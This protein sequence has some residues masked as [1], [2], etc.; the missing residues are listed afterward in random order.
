MDGTS[1]PPRC[2][3]RR[4]LAAGIALLAIVAGAGTALA[5]D[6]PGVPPA[7]RW[8]I[9][10][11]ALR[12]AMGLATEHW[13]FSPCGGRVTVTWTSLG[14]GVNAQSAWANDVDPYLQ[15]SRNTDCEIELS[16]STEWDWVKLCSVV[17]HEVGHLAGHDHVDDPEDLMFPVY[18]SPAPECAATPEPVQAAPV[19]PATGPAPAAAPAA[20]RPRAEQATRRPPARTTR[21]TDRRRKPAK[22]PHRRR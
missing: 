20:A 21:R 19:A 7:A 22:S 13:G 6:A 4:L 17:M 11:T 15:P 12:T 5:D 2:F 8:P 16:A 18:L 3:A 1:S 9:G 10:G 14:A